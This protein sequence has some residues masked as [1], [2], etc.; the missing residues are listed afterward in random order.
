MKN[1]ALWYI[2]TNKC[3]AIAV[4][5]SLTHTLYLFFLFLLFLATSF[6]KEELIFSHREWLRRALHL[7]RCKISRNLKCHLIKSPGMVSAACEPLGPV[8]WKAKF[9]QNAKKS[10][11]SLNHLWKWEKFLPEYSK[12]E[13][14]VLN[15][16][17]S[18]LKTMLETFQHWLSGEIWQWILGKHRR[19]WK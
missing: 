2:N 1:R 17:S 8:Y 5:I 11:L 18:S 10:F 15:R 9:I 4:L 6:F 12:Q 19:A 3:I 7:V 13:G 14:R 16:M